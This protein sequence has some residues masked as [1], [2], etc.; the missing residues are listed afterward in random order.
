MYFY[1][2]GRDNYISAD[3]RN[4]RQLERVFE[5]W[6]FDYVLLPGRRVWL[7]ELICIKSAKVLVFK[8]VIVRPV[9]C[10]GTP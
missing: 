9:N 7:L 4:S 5:K 10:Y 1:S 8:M 2:T 3:V 6:N